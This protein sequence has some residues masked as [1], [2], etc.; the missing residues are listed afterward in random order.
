[1]HKD[2]ECTFGILKGHL[3]ILKPVSRLHG[4]DV[5]DKIWLTCCALHGLLL[6]K[7]GKSVKWDGE[8]GLSDFDD[9]SDNIPFA[10]RRLNNGS[11]MRN[12]DTSRIGPSITNDEEDKNE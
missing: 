11:L 5:T 4:V 9:E 1:M 7:D 8:T 2:V 3:R 6:D 10:L 12:Y